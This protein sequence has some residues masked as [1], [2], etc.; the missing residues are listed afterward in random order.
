MNKNTKKKRHLTDRLEKYLNSFIINASAEEISEIS[1]KLAAIAIKK[2]QTE[3]S[4]KNEVTNTC[5]AVK[6]DLDISNR[7]PRKQYCRTKK[8]TNNRDDRKILHD[9]RLNAIINGL[10]VF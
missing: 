10:R 4:I 5:F 2:A 1:V 6:D 8:S 9:K 3:K 7:N